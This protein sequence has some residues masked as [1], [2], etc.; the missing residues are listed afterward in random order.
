MERFP[1]KR[2]SSSPEETEAIGR[3]IGLALKPG[4]S[5]ALSGG[6]GA[7]KTCIAR[8]I[9]AGLGIA[10]NIT[11]PTYTIVSE[12]PAGSRGI[13]LYHIDAYRLSGDEDFENTGAGEYIGMEGVTIIEWCDRIPRSIPPDALRIEIAISGPHSRIMI[14]SK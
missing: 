4:E 11:S 12:Y 13:P 5:V 2:I 6:L 9:A 1:T 3:E 8:G 14:I 10:E 7:G